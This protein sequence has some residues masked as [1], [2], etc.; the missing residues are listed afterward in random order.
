M[1]HFILAQGEL[2]GDDKVLNALALGLAFSSN[3]RANSTAPG[4]SQ[5]VLQ[6]GYGWTRVQSLADGYVEG[7]PLPGGATQ[8]LYKKSTQGG[9]VLMVSYNFF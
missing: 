8:P 6:L 5:L 2:G 9:P 4:V 1:S 3:R 7:A